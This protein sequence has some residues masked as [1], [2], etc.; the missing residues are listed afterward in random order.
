MDESSQDHSDGSYCIVRYGMS[1]AKAHVDDVIYD[2]I[3]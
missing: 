3:S 2:R 1:I